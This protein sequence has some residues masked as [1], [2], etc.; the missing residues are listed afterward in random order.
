VDVAC[1]FLVGKVQPLL[2]LIQDYLFNLTA[3]FVRSRTIKNRRRKTRSDKFPLTLHPTGQYCKNINGKIH[4]F[5]TDKKQALKR[6]L[7]QATCFHG[8]PSSTPKGSNGSMPLKELCDLYLR[9]QH[10]RVLAGGITARHYTDQI[11]SLS[12]FMSF[13]GKGRRIRGISTLDLQNYKRK[14][15]NAY[16][17]A[18]RPNLHI[19][20]MKAMFH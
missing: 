16:S 18:H 19:S 2:Q 15:Q 4:Y 3:V 10:A 8:Y 13:V 17:S 20:V 5:G 11:R 7:D 14:L 1:S 6:H 9:Y 12:R